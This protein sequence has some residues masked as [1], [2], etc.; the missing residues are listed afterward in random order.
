MVIAED[1]GG[2]EPTGLAEAAS[3]S[4][5]PEA[6]EAFNAAAS[7]PLAAPLVSGN[8]PASR[9]VST[10]PAR[11]VHCAVLCSMERSV[12]F[13][14]SGAGGG[15]AGLAGTAANAVVAAK[16]ESL[17]TTGG[18]DLPP[19]GFIDV[20]REAAWETP[21]EPDARIAPGALRFSNGRDTSGS[22]DAA[23]STE[24]SVP[25]V[26]D[27]WTAFGGTAPVVPPAIPPVP[28]ALA[29][30][31]TPPDPA[32]VPTSGAFTF[33]VLSRVPDDDPDS[34]PLFSQPAGAIGSSGSRGPVPR[35]LCEAAGRASG[36]RSE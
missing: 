33:A 31:V 3:A 27:V 21:E 6:P 30:R 5:A 29:I 9:A 24:R 11:V 13:I 20:L 10:P 15:P 26:A 16:K 34:G 12:S 7:C 18:T 28:A 19:V 22:R 25:R 32:L 1:A 8:A 36:K 2:A 4:E 23:V 17:D 14:R 35:P